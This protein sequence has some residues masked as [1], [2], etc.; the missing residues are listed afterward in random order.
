MFFSILL[1]ITLPVFLL[2]GAGIFA[3]RAFKLDLP[4]LTRL[5]FNILLPALVF[6]KTLDAGLT[7]EV[8]GGVTAVNVVHTVVL[9]AITWGL[10]SLPALR[11]HRPISSLAAVTPNAGNYGIPLAAM[12]YGAEGAH[13]MA[14][15]VM[16]Q[17]FFTITAG[18]WIVDSGRSSLRQII[19][20]FLKVPLLWAAVLALLLAGLNI[21]LPAPIR[22]ATEYLSAGLVPVALVTLGIQLSRSRAAGEVKLLSIIT[23][24]RLF[25]SPLLAVGLLAL[26]KTVSGDDLGVA[27]PVL[28]IAAGMP[29][30]VNVFILA[31]EYDQD[32][33]LASQ[34][35]F[36][37]TAL[38]ALT[39]TAWLALRG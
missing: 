5:C 34:T 17:I 35:I 15:I 18:I 12:A 26:W 25:L 24:F 39:L 2:I 7:P 19:T 11:S 4:T 8:F 32:S 3:D 38:S 33:H 21:Q 14:I 31:S 22:T 30:A 16:I 6:I 37:T 23:I 36:W 28:V 27:G 13:V 1:N 9:F 29:V 10:F 20:S